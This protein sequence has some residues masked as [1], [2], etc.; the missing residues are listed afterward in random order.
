MILARFRGMP[1]VSIGKPGLVARATMSSAKVKEVLTEAAPRSVTAL[2]P[3]RPTEGSMPP[4]E[5]FPYVHKWV[6]VTTGKHKSRHGEGS[7]LTCSKG[8]ETVA[9]CGEPMQPVYLHPKSMKELFR[10]TMLKNDVEYYAL[11]MT[12][13]PPRDPD[14]EMRAQWETLKNLAWVWDDPQA[15]T[16]FERGVLHPNW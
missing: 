4:P 2:T 10:M 7:S 12:D 9:S 6:K 11:Q 5:G 3:K 16:E 15:A 1:K 14:L 13:L 8:K